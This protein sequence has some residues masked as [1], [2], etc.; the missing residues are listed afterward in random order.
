MSLDHTEQNKYSS[1]AFN[2]QQ[3]LRKTVTCKMYNVIN[4]RSCFR[5]IFLIEKKWAWGAWNVEWSIEI[6]NLVTPPVIANHRIALHVNKVC[7][8]LR[9]P[10]SRTHP[11]Y[12]DKTLSLSLYVKIPPRE[13][14]AFLCQEHLN[15]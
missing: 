2:R 10:H 9:L 5:R 11:Y 14:H 4:A 15:F 1:R 12:N 7:I 6:N 8:S 13:K 3:V